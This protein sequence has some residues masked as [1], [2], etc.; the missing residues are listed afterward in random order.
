MSFAARLK[1]LQTALAV[2][3]PALIVTVYGDIAVPR[4]GVLWMGT[5][6]EVCATLGFSET[7]ARTAVSRLVAAGKLL[8]ERDG[9]RSYYRLTAEAGVEFSAAARL[10]Y[11]PPPQPDGFLIHH[12]PALEEEAARRAGLAR[13]GPGLFLGADAG[14][15]AP[16]HLAFRARVAGGA[17]ELKS[18]VAGLWDWEAVA[19]PYRQVIDLFAPLLAAPDP[20]L[21]PADALRARLL[22]V[23][24]Y[25]AALLRDPRLPAEAL[26]DDWPAAPAARLFAK[27]YLALSPLADRHIAARL[28]GR[29]GPLAE[30]TDE[31]RARLA[32]LENITENRKNGFSA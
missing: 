20:N 29:D 22:L 3:A 30:A 12:A 10:I 16:A 7:L 26:P 1:A 9:R 4:G 19:A 5:L 24:A 28:E 21:S 32:R 18:F 2:R 31:T 13:L 23:Q 6:I 8:G 25:R 14:G 27:T 11:G 15:A 17:A